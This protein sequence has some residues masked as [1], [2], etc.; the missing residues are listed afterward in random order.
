[1]LSLSCG[2]QRAEEAN[3]FGWPPSWSGEERP[4]NFETV[5]VEEIFPST[6]EFETVRQICIEHGLPWVKSRLPYLRR[7]RGPRSKAAQ[8]AFLSK[9]VV[10][11]R[12]R[13]IQIALEDRNWSQPVK[14]GVTMIVL[15]GL[16]PQ[17]ASKKTGINPKLLSDYA[18]RL[19]RGISAATFSG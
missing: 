3:A 9:D 7:P 16:K 4:S 19:E 14:D 5:K 11:A 18:K 17:E 2:V 10:K 1:V 13:E 15:E 12:A 8:R 6:L